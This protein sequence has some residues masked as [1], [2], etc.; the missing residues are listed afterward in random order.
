MK[1]I[2]FSF[3]DP[4]IFLCTGSGYAKVVLLFRSPCTFIKIYNLQLLLQFT[5]PPEGLFMKCSHFHSGL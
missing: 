2:T 5:T 3:Q 4:E 1:R